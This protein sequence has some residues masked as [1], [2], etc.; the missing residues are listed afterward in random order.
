MPKK[1][2]RP[3]NVRA[4]NTT[5]RSPKAQNNNKRKNRQ[6]NQKQMEVQALFNLELKEYV[7]RY[8]QYSINQIAFSTIIVNLR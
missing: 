5:D 3:K 2:H 7:D 6:I 4:D 1:I 8:E